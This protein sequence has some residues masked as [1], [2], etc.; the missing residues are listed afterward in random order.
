MF[1]LPGGKFCHSFQMAILRSLLV[2]REKLE[3]YMYIFE[4]CGLDE[5]LWGNF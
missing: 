5:N 4:T 3:V 2:D 1:Y